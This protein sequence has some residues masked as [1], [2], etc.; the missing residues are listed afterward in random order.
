MLTVRKT[1]LC[2]CSIQFRSPVR[3]FDEFGVMMV[4]GHL[5]DDE[6]RIAEQLPGVLEFKHKCVLSA[7]ISEGT[8]LPLPTVLCSV[9]RFGPCIVKTH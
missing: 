3:T 5:D 7:P 1:F 2:A 6:I 4:Y 8:Y 9:C